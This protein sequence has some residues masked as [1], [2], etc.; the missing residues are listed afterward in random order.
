MKRSCGNENDFN[1]LRV[2]LRNVKKKQHKD[3]PMYDSKD[4][5][6]SKERK[7]SEKV[8]KVQN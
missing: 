2:G 3:E 8:W 4:R 6:E 1:A 5:K 7:S